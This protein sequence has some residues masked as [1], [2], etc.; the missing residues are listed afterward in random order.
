M[1]TN[2]ELGDLSRAGMVPMAT[3]FGAGGS[4][5]FDGALRKILLQLRSIQTA[6]VQIPGDGLFG[7]TNLDAK[8]VIQSVIY[9]ANSSHVPVQITDY[10]TIKVDGKLEVA[11]EYGAGTLIVTFWPSIDDVPQPPP[12]EPY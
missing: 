4:G 11:G 10:A 8:S 6:V 5:V 9:I 7:I 12:P 3:D 2:Q 1:A